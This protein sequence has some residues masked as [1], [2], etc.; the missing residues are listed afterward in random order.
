MAENKKDKLV[1]VGQDNYLDS[2]N[3][4]EKALKNG[5]LVYVKFF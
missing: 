4:I 2:L 3:T 1:L 5:V